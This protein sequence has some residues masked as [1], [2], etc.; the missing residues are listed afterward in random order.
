M[1]PAL[2]LIAIV[3]VSVASAAEDSSVSRTPLAQ[4]DTA[5]V[6]LDPVLDGYD[7][8]VALTAPSTAHRRMFVVEQSGR[9]EI[10]QRP[11]PTAPWARAGVFLDV[12]DRVGTNF[13]T[14]LLGLAF[15]PRYH[16]N[17]RFYV[18]YTRKSDGSLMLV[19]FR[20][21]TARRADPSSGRVVLAIPHPDSPSHYSGWIAFGPD[22]YL[23]LGTGDG[24]GPGDPHENAQNPESLLGKI[25][26]LDPRDPDGSGPRRHT[27][28]PDNP[29]VDGPGR[30]LVWSIGL[31]NPWRD[32]FDPATGDLW[33]ADV[34][35]ELYE[36]IDHVHGPNAGKASNFGW[37]LCEGLHAYPAG[38]GLCAAD[39][40]VRPVIEIAHAVDG[41]HN[42][43]IV[44]GMVLRADGAPV[45]DGRYLFGD[46]CSGRIWVV[47]LDIDVTNGDVL[48]EPLDTDLN[49]TAFGQD[50][51]GKGYALDLAGGVWGLTVASP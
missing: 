50:A 33:I 27:V 35:Q 37:D 21:A 4:R 41:D 36:E 39:G 38:T 25:L 51:L 11:S 3:T 1:A 13:E 14:G 45:A 9:I 46:F 2:F 20:R 43:A 31:R 18:T 34:G 40:T 26:R 6:S 16:R 12:S 23:Y 32:T 42:C 49:L 30:D 24:G 29:F 48:P 5:S 47:P 15:D 28:P 17:G 7:R 22:G 19:E 8:P 44:G 10:A